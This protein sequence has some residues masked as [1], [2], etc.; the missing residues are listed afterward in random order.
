MYVWGPLVL[1]ICL[2]CFWIT[3]NFC[4]YLCFYL[5]KFVLLAREGLCLAVNKPKRKMKTEKEFQFFLR[6]IMSVKHAGFRGLLRDSN[7]TL[8]FIGWIFVFCQI[9]KL[10]NRISLW[11]PVFW[12]ICWA[13]IHYYVYLW[14]KIFRSLSPLSWAYLKLK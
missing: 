5:E 10:I 9:R 6:S 13:F 2:F 12:W 3:I 8:W 1:F 14:F 7:T 11:W 4:S